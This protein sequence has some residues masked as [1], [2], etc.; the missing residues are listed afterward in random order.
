MILNPA[1]PNERAM[2]ARVSGSSSITRIAESVCTE[3]LL[4]GAKQIQ[5]HRV[6]AKRRRI[7]PVAK[8]TDGRRARRF[9]RVQSD[10]ELTEGGSPVCAV[11]VVAARLWAS[12]VR[13]K[14]WTIPG[15]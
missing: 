6:A 2:E 9:N 13:A 12:H 8:Q 1:P 14:G 10:P 3:R 15:P 4:H 5:G 11:A 7:S